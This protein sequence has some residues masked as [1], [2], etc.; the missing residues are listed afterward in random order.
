MV[1]PPFVSRARERQDT[2]RSRPVLQDLEVAVRGQRVARISDRADDI[3]HARMSVDRHPCLTAAQGVMK[4]SIRP[5]ALRAG[6]KGRRVPLNAQRGG[7][8]RPSKR[9]H[10]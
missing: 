9:Y 6:A 5:E 7:A 10:R 1:A 2:A 3:A 4:P 8:F